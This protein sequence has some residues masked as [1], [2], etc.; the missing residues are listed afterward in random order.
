MASSARQYASTASATAASRAASMRSL[1]RFPLC[2]PSCG[3]DEMRWRWR[4]Q[5]P[6]F[7]GT[8]RA[9]LTARAWCSSH[10]QAPPPRVLPAR[11]RHLSDRSAYT[12]PCARCEATLTITTWSQN[13]LRS[14]PGCKPDHDR[15]QPR[16]STCAQRAVVAPLVDRPTRKPDR[17]GAQSGRYVRVSLAALAASLLLSS[18]ARPDQSDRR[19]RSAQRPPCARRVCRPVT[20]GRRRRPDRECPRAR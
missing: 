10:T 1:D 11:T 4:H 7:E 5:R 8:E 3:S 15:E 18:R 13:R 16:G 17:I 12:R 2:P 6:S 20:R 9:A 19:H 14:W